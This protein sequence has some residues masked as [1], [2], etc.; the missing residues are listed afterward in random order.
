MSNVKII[1]YLGIVLALLLIY[2]AVKPFLLNQPVNGDLL[3]TSIILICIAV[4]YCVTVFKPSWLKAV[5]FFE[6]IIIAVVGYSLLQIPYNIILAVIG[7]IILIVSILA[8]TQKL[9]NK[10]LRIFYRQ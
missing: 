7:L 3:A 10:V 6:G 9:P 5:L 1:K 2:E 8:Y 4:G